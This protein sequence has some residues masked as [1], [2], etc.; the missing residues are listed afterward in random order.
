MPRPTFIEWIIFPG[1]LI[2]GR[3]EL[4]GL[5]P[6]SVSWRDDKWVAR[7]NGEFVAEGGLN[8]CM[9]KCHRIQWPNA[10]GRV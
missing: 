8:R 6:Y 5:W 1:R 4:N 7:H 2:I 3:S 10:Y 9:M